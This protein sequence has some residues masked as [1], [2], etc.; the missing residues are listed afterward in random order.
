L[1]IGIIIPARLNSERLPN[2]VLRQFQGKS[3]IEH[4]W[5][6]VKLMNNQIECI[7]ATD[8]N[9]ISSVAENFGATVVKTKR[10]HP[11]GL[12]RAKEVLEDLDWDYVI[13][14][15]ADEILVV[16]KDL[17]DL[18]K[19]VNSK[20]D[21]Y[22]LITRIEDSNELENLNVVKCVLKQDRTILNI[23][24]KNGLISKQNKQLEFVKK[25][26][27]TFAVSRK[28]LLSIDLTSRSLI[29]LQESIEQLSILE[30]NIE[31]L[32]IEIENHFISVNTEEEAIQADL[33]LTN[34]KMQREIFSKY[35]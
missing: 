30:N 10:S 1:K 34:N 13:I 12:S 16:P 35:Q 24:R 32:G 26:C 8:S 18:F 27:G 19:E 21:F 23:F 28:L 4:T 22:N 14:L 5:Q 29:G 25:I 33:M 9:E 11:N 7:I 15:Q 3:M 31:I 6:R 17:D 20:Y 2:K